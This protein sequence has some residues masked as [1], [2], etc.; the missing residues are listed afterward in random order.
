MIEYRLK[1]LPERLENI[2]NEIGA[3]IAEEEFKGGK[4][5]LVYASENID[6]FLSGF[7]VE[8]SSKSVEET[9]WQ[10]KWKEFINEGWLNNSVYFVF[11]PKSFPD[12]RKTVFINPAL[13]FG[14][15][16]HGTTRIAAR[17]LEDISQGRTMLDIGTGSGILSIAAS[18][19]GAKMIWSFD[20][21]PMAMP[22]CLE[23][24]SNN[25][26]QNI[27]IWA[28]DTSSLK[29]GLKFNIVCANIISSVLISIKDEVS[30]M[31]KDFIIYSGILQTE[32]DEIISKLV[33][34]GWSVDAK[35]EIDEWCGVRLKNN[36]HV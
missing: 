36:N 4:S 23:N 20:A 13:A 28:G 1:T 29:K 34:N 8:F 27:H 5:Y 25:N 19:M 7:N 22:N 14:T 9:G 10:N 11:E 17:L 12:N 35:L 30:A 24:I 2:L 18:V 31:A 15:G 26:I 16:T 6:D 32:Y 3:F 21:D 33:P